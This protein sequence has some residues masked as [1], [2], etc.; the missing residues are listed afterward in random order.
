MPKL[1]CD[2]L[3]IS[4]GGKCSKCPTLVALDCAPGRERD[5][6]RLYERGYKKRM[7]NKKWYLIDV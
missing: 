3:K 7:K 1:L 4:G 5:S 2:V 6:G